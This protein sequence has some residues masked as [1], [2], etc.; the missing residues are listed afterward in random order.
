MI[1]IDQNTGLQTKEPLT[2]ISAAFQGKLLFGIYLTKVSTHEEDSV[3]ELDEI[4]FIINAN[5]VM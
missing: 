3:S 5:N 2:T 1:C 4:T